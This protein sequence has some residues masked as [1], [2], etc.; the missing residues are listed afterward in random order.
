MEVVMFKHVVMWKLE[1]NALGNNKLANAK[2]I[3]E[4]LEALKD[5]LD[6][7]LT[8]E[9]G[10]DCYQTEQSFDVV[11]ISEFEN[12]DYFKQYAVHPKHQEVVKFIKQ[13]VT[14]RIAVDYKK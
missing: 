2:L 10:I 3:K 4:E 12:E 6:G 11:L 7:I 13:V 1:D 5:V 8:L 9:V 14:N